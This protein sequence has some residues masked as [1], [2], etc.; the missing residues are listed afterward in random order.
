MSE[1]AL[2][3]L[4]VDLPYS[5]L[6]VRHPATGEALPTRITLAGPEHPVRK[7]ALF[8]RVRARLA[9]AERDGKMPVT[10]PTEDDAD[11][12]AFAASCTLGWADLPVDG[13]FLPFS[14]GAADKLYADPRYRWLRNQVVVA[15]NNSALFIGAC[16]TA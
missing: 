13:A 9:E 10:D 1:T 5:E 2:F 16:A 14:I 7:A 11:Q 12:T 8:S 15:L 4:P 3:E 6:V